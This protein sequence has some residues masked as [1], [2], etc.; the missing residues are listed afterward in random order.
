MNFRIAIQDDYDYMADHSISRG[1]QKHSPGQLDYVYTLEHEDEVLCIGG[2][3]MINLT[4]AWCWIDISSEAGDH[5]VMMYRVIRD[6]IENFC[7]EHKIRRL[8]SYVECDF[9]EA[10]TLVQHL[11]FTKE[12]IMEKFMG[13]RDAFM[14]KKVI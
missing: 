13:D 1:I 8:Q 7:E 12:S 5:I 2:F 3:Q 14:Y 10:I 11:G 9:T 6:W 4:T